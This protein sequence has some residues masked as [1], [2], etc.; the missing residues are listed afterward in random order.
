MAVGTAVV[1]ALGA[2][3]DVGDG[4]RGTPLRHQVMSLCT[5]ALTDM[6]NDGDVR[7]SRVSACLF[8]ACARTATRAH[9]G[10]CGIVFLCRRC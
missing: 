8:A 1:A 3:L 4:S 7:L 10:V 5:R 6:G 2:G 9:S